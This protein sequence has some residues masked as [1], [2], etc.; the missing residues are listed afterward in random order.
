MSNLERLCAET[1]ASRLG[2]V[3]LAACPETAR[4]GPNVGENNF[5]RHDIFR[6]DTKIRDM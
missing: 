2:V 5:F 6:F 1:R 3:K 4:P